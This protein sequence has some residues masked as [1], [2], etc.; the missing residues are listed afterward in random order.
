ME[1][2]CLSAHRLNI[3]KHINLTNLYCIKYVKENYT[4]K[5]ILFTSV[6]T[7]ENDGLTNK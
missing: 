4:L 2:S 7:V 3:L 6:F 1:T 5:E